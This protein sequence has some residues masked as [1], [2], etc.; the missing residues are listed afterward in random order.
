MSIGKNLNTIRKKW[1]DSQKSFGD[2]S[3]LTNTAVSEWEMGDNE[4]SSWILI[5][6]EKLTGIPAKRLYLEEISPD[7]VHPVPDRT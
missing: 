4:P 1:R 3:V 5:E 2:G 7:E 6:L